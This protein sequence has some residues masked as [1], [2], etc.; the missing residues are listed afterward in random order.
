[1]KLAER[2]R[3]SDLMIAKGLLKAWREDIVLHRG[4]RPVIWAH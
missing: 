4:F 3:R 2:L 1:M